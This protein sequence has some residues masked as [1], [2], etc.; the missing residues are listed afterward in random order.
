MIFWEKINPS[1][2]ATFVLRWRSETGGL[3]KNKTLHL[4]KYAGRCMKSKVP[5]DFWLRDHGLCRKGDNAAGTCQSWKSKPIEVVW[6]FNFKKMFKTFFCFRIREIKAV[7]DQNQRRSPIKYRLMGWCNWA[8]ATQL[9]PDELVV[10][11]RK[12]WQQEDNL[13]QDHHSW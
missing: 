2:T 3:N 8:E 4:R 9:F 5:K 1:W 11:W 13:Q 7:T 6:C 10:F 12:P